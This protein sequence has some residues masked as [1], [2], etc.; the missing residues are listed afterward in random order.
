M[1]DLLQSYSL[2]SYMGLDFILSADG[3]M[4]T[5]HDARDSVAFHM[6]IRLQQKA[7]ED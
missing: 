1:F 7:R 3:Y 5:P 6:L 2:Y 4:V